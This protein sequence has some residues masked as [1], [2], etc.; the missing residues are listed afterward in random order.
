MLWFLRRQYKSLPP[1]EPTLG[2]VVPEIGGFW[3]R[4]L[5][6]AA[7]V[8][9]SNLLYNLFDVAD[10]YMIVHTSSA[11]DP[12]AVV[13]SYHSSRIVPLLLVSIAAL[14][15]TVILPHLSHDWEA[16][17]RDA[18][19]ARMNLTLKLLGLLLFVGSIAILLGA[20]F[21]F[22]VAFAGKFRGGLDVLPWTLTYCAWFGMVTMAQ[23]YLWCAERARLSCL[24]LFIGLVMNIGL[25]LLLLPRFG[26]AGAVWATAAANFVALA[27]IFQFNAW[28]GM[29]IERSLL[30]VSLL[31]LT[32]G[33][34]PFAAVA[35][36][37]AVIVGIIT[38]DRILSRDEKRQL[39]AVLNGY[40]SRFRP[41]ESPH[42]AQAASIASLVQPGNDVDGCKTRSG[43]GTGAKQFASWRID[44]SRAAATASDVHHHLHAR[45]RG[46]DLAFELIA[47]NRPLTFFARIVLPQGTRR[48][49]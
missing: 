15:G 43:L 29:K 13:G 48:A 16:G 41:L 14:L 8:W 2:A 47:T 23:M 45:R 22:N 30:L 6:F 19:S 18:V 11:A 5:P 31:P 39:C 4:L 9:V 3:S 36:L 34:G 38:T 32:L 12:L 17:R 40:V 26:L 42:L 28:L 10:R 21:L 49:R 33:L 24:A 27:L 44:R 20:P 25:N 37:V 1:G 7:W 46:R 35:A